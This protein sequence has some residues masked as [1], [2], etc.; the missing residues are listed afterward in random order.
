MIHQPAPL[1]GAGFFCTRALRKLKKKS[2][3]KIVKKIDKSSF[4]S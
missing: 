3:E 1:F 4:L 2:S